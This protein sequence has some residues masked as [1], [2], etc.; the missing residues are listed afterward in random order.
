MNNGNG[1]F[2]L[3]AT[4]DT[5][6]G[7]GDIVAGDFNGDDVIDLVVA[8][9]VGSNTMSILMGNGDGTFQERVVYSAPQN[10]GGL[11]QADIDK[12]GKLDLVMSSYVASVPGWVA[13]MFGNGGG[14]FQTAPQTFFT[15]AGGALTVA[16]V[17][18]DGWL[19]TLGNQ[20]GVVVL[21]NAGDWSPAPLP[22]EKT[23]LK[24]LEGVYT[25]SSPE[26]DQR[27]P[28]FPRI[29]NA[30]VD[31]GAFEVRATG[32]P[33]ILERAHPATLE[34]FILVLSTIDPESIA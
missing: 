8:N 24:D 27:G 13:V 4:H 32:M 33:S 14:S 16:D 19:D 23:T 12:D 17:N 30:A 6:H 5:G 10:P 3:T 25:G 21:L 15:G 18:Q 22:A 1:A 26:W 29:V 7:G 11:N 28:G 2:S 20:D 31:I 9:G 34:R